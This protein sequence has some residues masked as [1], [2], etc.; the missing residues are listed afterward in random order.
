MYIAR[1][2]NQVWFVFVFYSIR[3]L[4]VECKVS[5]YIRCPGLD[6]ESSRS[7]YNIMQWQLQYNMAVILSSIS[8][9]ISISIIFNSNWWCWKT[10]G[11]KAK[12][13]W[14]IRDRDVDRIPIYF[15]EAMYLLTDLFPSDWA[16]LANSP[17]ST[18]AVAAWT[19]LAPKVLRPEYWAHFPAS[20]QM[21]SNKSATN[22]LRTDIA[23]FDTPIS[24]C[25]CFNTL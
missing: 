7:I 9:S 19:S 16:C 3:I 5:V 14:R 8:I 12:I 13:E 1:T 18:N 23:F 17:G 4:F 25:T 21:R 11:W 6:M 10:P 24:G 20:E 22:E 15:I 2:I